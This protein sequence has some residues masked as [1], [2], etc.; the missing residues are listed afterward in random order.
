MRPSI[1][2]RLQSLGSWLARPNIRDG[3]ASSHHIYSYLFQE[4]EQIPSRTRGQLE[5]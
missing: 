2:N 5:V 4:L 1:D 3:S